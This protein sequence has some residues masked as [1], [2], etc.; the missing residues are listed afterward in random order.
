[1]FKLISKTSQKMCSFIKKNKNFLFLTTAIFLLML[2]PAHTVRA[3]FFSWVPDMIDILLN[4]PLNIAI[5]IAVSLTAFGLMAGSALV[6]GLY[7]LVMVLANALFKISV[8]IAVSP[9]SSG[10]NEVVLTGW[11]FTLG[12]VNMFFALTLTF[13]GLATILRIKEYEAKKLLPKLIGIAILVNFTPVIIGF[14]VDAGNLV[15]NFFIE[16]TAVDNQM[17]I[18]E[19]LQSLLVAP[20][21]S[22]IE[23]LMNSY[24]FI[25]GGSALNSI[26]IAL[27]IL[28][29]LLVCLIYAAFATYVFASILILFFL[30]IIMLWFLT[31]LSPIAFFSYI[32]P[33]GSRLR[34]LFP[35]ILSWEEWWKEF[36]KWVVVGI[37]FGLFYYLAQQTVMS[38]IGDAIGGMIS[39]ELN[40][41]SLDNVLI[42]GEVVEDL[43][44]T[45]T[46]LLPQI[47]SLFIL[48]KGYEISKNAAPVMAQSMLDSGKNLAQKGVDAYTGGMTSFVRGGAKGAGMATSKGMGKAAGWLEEKG[49]ERKETGGRSSAA[50]WVARRGA[51]ILRAGQKATRTATRGVLERE[52]RPET[53]EG[54]SDMDTKAKTKAMK[55]MTKKQK[56]AHL[57]SMS[58]KEL[59][60]MPEEERKKL[61]TFADKIAGSKKDKKKYKGVLKKMEKAGITSAKIKIA[62][63]DDPE[64]M[65]EKIRKKMEE[66]K[67]LMKDDKELE[68]EIKIKVETSPKSEEEIMKDLAAQAMNVKNLSSVEDF[69]SGTITSLG[70]RLGSD[71]LD[72]WQFN[73][74]RRKKGKETYNKLTNEAG[75]INRKYKTEEDF[76]ELREK[77]EDLAKYAAV[78]KDGQ[79]LDFNVIDE[80]R[81]KDGKVNWSKTSKGFNKYQA[82]KSKDPNNVEGIYYQEDKLQ[83]KL[84]KRAQEI[85]DDRQDGQYKDIINNKDINIDNLIKSAGLQPGTDEAGEF[86]KKWDWAQAKREL[87]QEQ[88]KE[89]KNLADLSKKIKEKARTTKDLTDL[90]RFQKNINTTIEKIEEQK[91]KIN[92]IRKGFE[93]T[94]EEFYDLEKYKTLRNEVSATRKE[95]SNTINKMK[96]LADEI[97]E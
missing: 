69:D 62:L 29:E 23:F 8:N 48:W 82:L 56:T 25:I 31:I 77:N 45:I 6:A 58:K 68:K 63:A 55:S 34:M 41:G 79:Y 32:F 91:D 47:I 90:Q 81:E 1:M 83:E 24:S 74:I 35:D 36:L 43:I 12:F 61:E 5:L 39:D 33:E 87:V 59:Q 66:T 13:I 49:E 46:G 97:E 85:Y 64:K 14:F 65:K 19:T 50:G 60:S 51:N 21:E 4:L 94:E 42:S 22:L 57:D 7:I 84:E 71:Q 86:I 54:W 96:K 27:G 15:T 26:I 72:G 80:V 67:E 70:F 76:Y 10:I 52:K 38:G 95:L 93:G 28:L 78:S 20:M 92:E 2:T 75:G 16:R 37:P 3:D 53:I 30:R 44:Y 9:S 18:E 40:L 88:N 89:I 17:W 11:N 73:N